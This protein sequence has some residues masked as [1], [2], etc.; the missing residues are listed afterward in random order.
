MVKFMNLNVLKMKAKLLTVVMIGCH[1]SLS[2]SISL[3]EQG[4][5]LA[6]KATHQQNDQC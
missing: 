5:K 6:E 1:I 4:E 2:S 3:A